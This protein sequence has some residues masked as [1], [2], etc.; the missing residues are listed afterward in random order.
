MRATEPT[1]MTGY[2][3]THCGYGCDSPVPI[4]AGDCPHCAGDVIF[5]IHRTA[6]RAL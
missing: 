1:D 5:D 2:R 6:P 3:C 4:G